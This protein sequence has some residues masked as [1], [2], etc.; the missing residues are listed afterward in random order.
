MCKLKLLSCA[1]G[2][3]THH[4]QYYIDGDKE[5]RVVYLYTTLNKERPW[6]YRVCDAFR[7][8]FGFENKYGMYAE[9]VLGEDSLEELEEIYKYIKGDE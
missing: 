7:Y 5:Y 8:L 3:P 1:C 2:S 9:V 6:Y 4:I